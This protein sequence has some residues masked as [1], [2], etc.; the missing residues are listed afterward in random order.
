MS[1][2]TTS[3]AIPLPHE[4]VATLAHR[5]GRHV[6]AVAF[7]IL[8]DHAQA[9][10]VQQEVFLRLLERPM[11]EVVTWQAM[12]TTLTARLAIDRLRQRKRWQL[13]KSLWQTSLMTTVDD[14]EQEAL[15]AERAERLRQEIA[16]LKPRE[17]ECFTLRC[18]LA[19][20]ITDIAIATGM[21]VNH[22]GVCL[23]RATRALESRLG[24]VFNTIPEIES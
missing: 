22:V 7:R 14:P 1:S 16:R 20:D 18:I 15:Q 12:L 6:F 23:H 21:S 3:P 17:A 4:E 24:R 11:S 8:G 5:Y 9:E 13:L 10:D 2:P 19:M